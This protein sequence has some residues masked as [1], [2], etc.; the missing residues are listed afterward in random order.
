MDL[1]LAASYVAMYINF[2]ST[3]VIYS[4]KEVIALVIIHPSRAWVGP[5]HLVELQAVVVG[6]TYYFN[7]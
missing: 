5:M 3:L 4:H 6:W 2:L 1:L 7:S